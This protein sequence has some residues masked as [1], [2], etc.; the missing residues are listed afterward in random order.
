M[1]L[2]AFPPV[3]TAKIC[4]PKIAMKTPALFSICWRTFSLYPDRNA[5]HLVT[6]FFLL[7]R[8]PSCTGH[9][10]YLRRIKT[11][12]PRSFN[13]FQENLSTW[14]TYIITFRYVVYR[15][16]SMTFLH[17]LRA[18]RSSACST[19]GHFLSNSPYSPRPVC[20]RSHAVRGHPAYPEETKN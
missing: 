17:L 13:V 3:T 18:Q 2:L 4:L 1:T 12:T 15:N 8:T 9:D 5:F 11:F 6:S 20:L 19:S 14:R 16:C 7:R 10:L